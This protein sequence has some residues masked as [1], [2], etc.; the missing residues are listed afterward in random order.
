MAGQVDDTAAEAALWGVRQAGQARGQA[1]PPRRVQERGAALEPVMRAPGSREPPVAEA[2][3]PNRSDMSMLWD[4]KLSAGKPWVLRALGAQ[5]QRAGRRRVV[6]AC[7]G[8]Q[9]HLWVLGA[10]CGASTTG[11][12]ECQDRA[13]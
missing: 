8:A 12:S 7:V 3:G 2:L 13:G 1:R 9:V 11:A 5:H 6:G 10:A 4:P